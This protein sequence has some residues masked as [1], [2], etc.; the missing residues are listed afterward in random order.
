MSTDLYAGEDKENLEQN[1][2]TATVAGSGS[3]WIMHIQP[4]GELVVRKYSKEYF[5]H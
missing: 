3:R 1:I 4:N 2:G 5:L